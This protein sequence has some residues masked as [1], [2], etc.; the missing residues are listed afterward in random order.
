MVGFLLCCWLVSVTKGFDVEYSGETALT[1][2]DM[3]TERVS[4]IDRVISIVTSPLD[5]NLNLDNGNDN[6]LQILGSGK[7][8]GKLS[9]K[10]LRLYYFAIHMELYK[11]LCAVYDG[12]NESHTNVFVPVST[13]LDDLFL[14]LLRAWKRLDEYPFA[15]DMKL[16]Q[17]KGFGSLNDDSEYRKKLWKGSKKYFIEDIKGIEELPRTQLT[18]DLR[19]TF[20]QIDELIEKHEEKKKLILFGDEIIEY[21]ILK[22]DLNDFTIS[23]KTK[24]NVPFNP[25]TREFKLLVLLM[26]SVGKAIKYKILAQE[27]ELNAFDGDVTSDVKS[28]IHQIK[29][30]V[31]HKLI[32]LGFLKKEAK[33]VRDY[34]RFVHNH[35]AIID[36]QK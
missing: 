5:K 9:T 2:V 3:Y 4:F 19:L 21:G 14:D 15:Q 24:T 23:T 13:I 17:F 25:N 7:D 26:K 36:T 28:D 35:G 31:Y 8:I 27:L 22:I 10:W 32:D 6:Y 33:T 29:K 34:I 12:Y 11:V 16:A 20:R 1:Y 30:G 18:N